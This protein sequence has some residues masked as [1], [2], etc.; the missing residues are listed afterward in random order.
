[1]LKLN[2]FSQAQLIQNITYKR[3]TYI[4]TK[5]FS[6][7]IFPGTKN[8]TVIFIRYNLHDCATATYSRDH[9]RIWLL[10]SVLCYC[11]VHLKIHAVFLKEVHTICSQHCFDRCYCHSLFF[12]MHLCQHME[13]CRH[14]LQVLPSERI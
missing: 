3:G 2:T 13:V 11:T 9:R 5:T 12:L 14:N 6:E 7:N 10:Y 8:K 4:F 1:M